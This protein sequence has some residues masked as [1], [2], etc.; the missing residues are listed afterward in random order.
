MLFDGG[1]GETVR[2]RLLQEC[3]VHTLLRLPTGIFYAQGVKANVLFFDRKPGAKAAWTKRLWVYDLRTNAHFT[4]KENPMKRADLD[5]FVACD[6]PGERHKRK[7][8]WSAETPE[9]RFRAYEYEELLAR[10]KVSL[11][12]T[13]LRDESLEDSATL[14]DPDVLAQEIADDLRS[15]LGQ[16]EDLLG[17]LAQRPN[18]AGGRAASSRRFGGAGRGRRRASALG[19]AGPRADRRSADQR[20]PSPS[21][22]CVRLLFRVRLLGGPRAIRDVP[23]GADAGGIYLG[24]FRTRNTK[25]VFPGYLLCFLKILDGINNRV[26][27]T[28]E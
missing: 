6:R 20:P 1:A 11:D 4:L 27:V 8:T 22:P 24:L 17:D 12:L 26:A 16:I 13:W 10:D 23:V 2:R 25:G 28:A 14:P 19:P 5:D 21:P 15:A 3:D 18:A 7:P 9:G